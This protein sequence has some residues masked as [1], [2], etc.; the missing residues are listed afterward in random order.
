DEPGV[1]DDR[2]R[3]RRHARREQ[4]PHQQPGEQEDREA[5]D[6][7]PEDELE[8]DV[9]HHQVQ[10]R[11]EHRPREAEDAV[12]VLDLQLGAGERHEQLA[13]APDV[14]EPFPQPDLRRAEARWAF[15][16]GSGHRCAGSR[17]YQPTI[18]G[19]VLPT[20]AK[21]RIVRP[22]RPKPS[23]FMS[24]STRTR[25]SANA[26]GWASSLLN[27][28]AASPNATTSTRSRTPS[29]GRAVMIWP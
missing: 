2:A 10:R 11:V 23:D 15:D 18:A 9:E 27:C 20:A 28:S 25:C 14:A 19:P 17:K 3:R 24:R 29:L 22:W 13:V 26:P 6:A 8:D 21:N 16:R 1:R 7:A 5:R 12:L 4:V